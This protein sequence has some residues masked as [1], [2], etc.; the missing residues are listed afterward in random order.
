MCKAGEIY[1]YILKNDIGT[2]LKAGLGLFAV[3]EPLGDFAVV[4]PALPFSIVDTKK[5]C[6]CVTVGEESKAEELAF[7]TE[8]SIKIFSK[9]LKK[10]VAELT[11]KL[12]NVLAE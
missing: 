7:L 10:K 6:V 9:D 2:I 11:P 3:V 8:Y 4:C 12:V 1:T 5:R